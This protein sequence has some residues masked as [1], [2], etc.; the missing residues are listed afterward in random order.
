MLNANQ[1]LE[2]INE[3]TKINKNLKEKKVDNKIEKRVLNYNEVIENFQDKFF[4][5]DITKNQEGNFFFLFIM[6]NFYKYLLDKKS[7]N[8]ETN[9]LKSKSK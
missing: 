4:S 5:N 2:N 3:I 1:N 9:N 8:I 7:E 6:E